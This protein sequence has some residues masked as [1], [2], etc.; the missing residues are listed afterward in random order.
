LELPDTYLEFSNEINEVFTFIF[1]GSVVRDKCVL[2][3][4]NNCIKDPD[5]LF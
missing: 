2:Q 3:P 5:K 1:D 4:F